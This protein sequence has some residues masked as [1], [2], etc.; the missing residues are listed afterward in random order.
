MYAYCSKDDEA[1][2]QPQSKAVTEEER[3]QNAEVADKERTGLVVETSI[4]VL[5]QDEADKLPAA[6][7]ESRDSFELNQP[8]VYEKLIISP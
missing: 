8:N 6:S 5:D 7:S 1:N 2:Q 3:F 4:A